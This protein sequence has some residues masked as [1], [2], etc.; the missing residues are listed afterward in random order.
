MYSLDLIA[1]ANSSFMGKDTEISM[2]PVILELILG[3]CV[4]YYNRT[5]SEDD[6]FL[7]LDNVANDYKV[8]SAEDIFNSIYK[9]MYDSLKKCGWD[10]RLRINYRSIHIKGVIHRVKIVMD[11]NSTLKHYVKE[12]P[13]EKERVE[14]KVDDNPSLESLNA[15]LPKPKRKKTTKR[16]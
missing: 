7:E 5:L 2:K 3:L 6:L 8:E 4:G 11:L 14:H 1:L 9:D 12:A 13:V 15:L 10:R 16:L